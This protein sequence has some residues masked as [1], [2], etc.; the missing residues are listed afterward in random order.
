MKWNDAIYKLTHWESWNSFIKYIPLI[1]VWCWY[2]IRS[3]N[4]WFFTA[5]NP[6]LTFGGME[7]E[8]KEEMYNHL[9]EGTFPKSVFIEHEFG[10]DEVM[11]RI[12]KAGITFP[13]VVKPNVGMMGYMFRKVQNWEELE[14]YHHAINT[15]Y[16]VQ[17]LVDFPLEVGLFYYRMPDSNHGTISGLLTKTP[18]YIIGDGV[19]NIEQLL[20]KHEGVRFKRD[21]LKRKHSSYL[22]AILPF[23][24]RFFLS[25]ASNRTQ[26][27]DLKSIHSEIDERLVAVMDKI[28]IFSNSFFYG[29]YDIK[30]KSIEDLKEGKNF[31]ILEFNG[32]GSGVQQIFGNGYSLFK[33]VSII[34][35]HWKMMYRISNFNLKR[36][37][38]K[39]AFMDG[40]RVLKKAQRNNK[41]L[42]MLDSE[43]VL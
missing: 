4:F 37:I 31:Y 11:R 16:V 26:G 8:T 40:M 5:A 7:G 35:H 15:K 36:G 20:D 19:N 43:F 39:W 21:E 24:E 27:G 34:A 30:C 12:E 32:S 6:T 25:D 3:G 14:K 13:L 38:G 23:G 42:R 22:A 9:P 2:C 29:R 10:F 18:P 17:H 33:A 41:A 28:S 1:P